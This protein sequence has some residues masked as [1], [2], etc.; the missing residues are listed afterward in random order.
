MVV[1]RV[2]SLS[3][4]VPAAA[5]LAILTGCGGATP[6]PPEPQAMGISAA[7]QCFRLSMRESPPKCQERG[8][9]ALPPIEAHFRIDDVKAPR[10]TDGTLEVVVESQAFDPI[11][12]APLTIRLDHKP[13]PVE[14]VAKIPAER[15][16][17]SLFTLQLSAKAGPDVFEGEIDSPCGD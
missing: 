10:T 5:A 13:R 4:E 9:I 1:F 16:E 2:R 14:F 17:C 8:D 12:V 3:F 6:P 15:A 7:R 11:R